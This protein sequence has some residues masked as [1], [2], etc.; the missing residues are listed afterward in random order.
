MDGNEK[1]LTFAG[2]ESES[3]GAVVS[4]PDTLVDPIGSA[5][6]AGP[7][8]I[9]F[10]AL[11]GCRAVAAVGVFITHMG[12]LTGFIMRHEWIG[13]YMARMEVGVSIFF[14][15]SG[16]LLYR[17]MVAARFAGDNPRRRDI[18]Q[19]SDTADLP[20]LLGSAHDRGVRSQGAWIRGAPHRGCPLSVVAHL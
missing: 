4:V 10:P 11:D 19:A 1:R 13:Q 14:V 16:F 20:G 2:G 9:R 3:S 15:L 6:K 12:L 18:C 5:P 17:P 7:L 8:P